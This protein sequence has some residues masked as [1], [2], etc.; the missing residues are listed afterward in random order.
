MSAALDPAGV[1]I[2]NYNCAPLAL[3]AALSA[4]GDD[5]S[6]IVVIIDNAS[7]D[8]SISYFEAVFADRR[9]HQTAAPEGGPAPVRF[10]DPAQL[11]TTVI[12]E[13]GAGPAAQL[14]VLKAAENR[15]F[16]AG[17][18][19]GMAFLAERV[20]AGWFLL[21]NPDALLA[22]GAVDAFRARLAEPPA[23]LCGASVLRFEAGYPAQAFGGARL[24]PITLQG[25]NI[26]E[27]CGLSAAPGRSAVETAMDYPLGAVMACRA[28]YRE[29]AGDLDERY[30][31]YFEEADWARRGGA[32]RPPVWAPGAVIYHRHGASAGSREKPGV[33]GALSDYHMARSRMLF[34]LKWNPALAPLILVLTIG[35]ALRR[36]L[37]GRWRQSRAVLAGALNGPPI[38]N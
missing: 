27:G 10:A 18:N 29:I 12:D 36:M 21:L 7:T 26:G 25:E 13:K 38:A 5:P 14:T 2:V 16:A 22:K 6:A 37:K 33:R 8:E 31:L 9:T 23:G 1:V 15:G 34:V 20:S 17:C 4:I 32:D 30:F 3:D 11:V 28:E 24:N 35:Q 19:L